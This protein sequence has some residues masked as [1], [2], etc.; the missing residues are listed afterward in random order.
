MIYQLEINCFIYYTLVV[1]IVL[2]LSFPSNT[3]G[4]SLL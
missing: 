3:P 1:L 2:A 4:L